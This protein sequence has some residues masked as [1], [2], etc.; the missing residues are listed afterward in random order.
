MCLI[1]LTLAFT[2]TRLMNVGGD[3]DN[4]GVNGWGDVEMNMLR[5][6]CVLMFTITF[7]SIMPM[8]SFYGS[9]DCEWRWK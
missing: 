5:M 4:S 9:V 1:A 2:V 3:Y 8:V 7:R 6:S